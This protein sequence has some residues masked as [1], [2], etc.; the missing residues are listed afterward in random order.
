M[1]YGF[2]VPPLCIIVR[3]R[4]ERAALL[5][6][7]LKFVAPLLVGLLGGGAAGAY[8]NEWY[9]RKHARLQRIPLIERVNRLVNPNLQGG[10]TLARIVG[11]PT[12]PQLVE[13]NNLREYQLTL[14]NTSTVHLQNVEIQFEFPAQDV[15]EYASPRT[16]LSKTALQKIETSPPDAIAFPAVFRW[17]IPQLPSGDSVEFTFQAESPRSEDYEAALY[18]NDRVII[19]KV[20]GEPAPIKSVHRRDWLVIPIA[21]LVAVV[22]WVTLSWLGVMSPVDKLSVVREAG[23]NL[24]IVSS[25]SRY[26]QDSNTRIIQNRIFN[27]GQSCVVKSDQLDPKGSFTIGAGDTVTRESLAQSRPKLVQ[28]EVFVGATGTTLKKTLIPLYAE[29]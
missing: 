16:A 3:H 8:L 17:L 19:E 23:C 6:E 18:N 2:A 4:R 5:P 14:R 26:E 1:R 22:L 13:L 20:K 9:R 25:F 21:L 10:I 7:L 28:T 24:R 11:D 15:Q 12:H 29:P 27:A